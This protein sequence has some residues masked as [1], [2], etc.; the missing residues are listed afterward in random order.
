MLTFIFSLF[1]GEPH[2]EMLVVLILF[3][4][5]AGLDLGPTRIFSDSDGRVQIPTSPRHREYRENV[6]GLEY[7]LPLWTV[8]TVK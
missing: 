3:S 7:Q 6:S 2:I 8:L 1:F 5:T 4:K